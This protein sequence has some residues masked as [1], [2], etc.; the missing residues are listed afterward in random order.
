MFKRLKYKFAL[1]TMGFS[2]LILLVTFSI[3]L[4][5]SY[6]Q[7][8][9]DSFRYLNSTI[10]RFKT[11]VTREVGT[12]R[13]PNNQAPNNNFDNSPPFKSFSVYL[14]NSNEIVILSDI[15]DEFSDEVVEASVDEVINNS[16]ATGVLKDYSLRYVKEN[17]QNGVVISFIDYSYEQEYLQQQIINYSIVA[18]ISLIALFLF[19]LYLSSKSIAPIE[20]SINK[21][22][23]FIE[24][25]SHELKTPLT[26]MLSNTALLLDE[27]N[28]NNKQQEYLT[29]I[30]SE[31]KRM[32]TLIQDML[33]LSSIEN[34][35]KLNIE[36]I[37]LSEFI[38]ETMLFFESRFYEENR[39]L[40]EDITD[41]IIVDGDAIELKQLLNILL[42]NACK[43]SSKNSTTII[44]SYQQRS[45]A[46]VEVSNKFDDDINRE[47]LEKLFDRFYKVDQARTRNNSY[48]LGLAIAKEIVNNHSGSI[49]IKIIDDQIF[50]IVKLPLG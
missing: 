32:K 21:Q 14:D 35:R 47:E 16:N 26:V 49:N 46:V 18:L 22:K 38:Y 50:F 33:Y 5:S 24:N 19:S 23:Q 45:Y 3:L 40:K 39:S 17:F 12:I 44:K 8:E 34:K 20:K 6:K 30:E 13:P 27:E 48:G 9:T 10:D 2:G 36:K 31:G 28:I 11:T 42:D 4:F 7:M 25:A 15:N 29:Y 43:Y 41:N 37:N 1:I